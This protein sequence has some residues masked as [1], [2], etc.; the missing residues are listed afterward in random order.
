MKKEKYAKEKDL[1]KKASDWKS[2]SSEKRSSTETLIKRIAAEEKEKKEAKFTA[3]LSQS[4]FEGLKSL[5]QEKGMGYQTLLGYIIH[6]YVTGN[7]V[8]VEEIR[9]VIPGLKVKAG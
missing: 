4:D 8:D 7:L 6:G 2:I 9:K 1:F 3:R 5:A